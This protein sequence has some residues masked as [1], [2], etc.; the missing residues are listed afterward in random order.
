MKL[1]TIMAICSE[2]T[3]TDGWQ[4]LNYG[5]LAVDIAAKDGKL[6]IIKKIDGL[7]DWYTANSVSQLIKGEWIDDKN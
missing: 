5:S 7:A 3:S 2:I 6:F 4:S 1:T